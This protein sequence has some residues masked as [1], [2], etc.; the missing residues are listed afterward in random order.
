MKGR[1]RCEE[2]R[3]EAIQMGA[4]ALDCFAALAMT[5]NSMSSLHRE[6]GLGL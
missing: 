5:M 1:R 2:R 6:L 3:D 4:T